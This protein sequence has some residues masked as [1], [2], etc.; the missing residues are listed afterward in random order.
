MLMG[1]GCENGYPSNPNLG[2][3]RP[4]SFKSLSSR[5]GSAGSAGANT[6]AALMSTHAGEEGAFTKYLPFTSGVFSTP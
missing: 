4:S 5:P 3:N 1:I 6:H 2:A